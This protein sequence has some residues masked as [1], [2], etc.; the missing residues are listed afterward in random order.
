MSKTL[1]MRHAKKCQCIVLGSLIRKIKVPS[2][3]S[4]FKKRE[5]NNSKN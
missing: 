1:N 5:E 4:I 3:N 2:Q